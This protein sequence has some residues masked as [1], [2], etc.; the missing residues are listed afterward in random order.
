MDRKCHPGRSFILSVA[1]VRLAVDSVAR[2]ALRRRAAAGLAQLVERRLPKPK[3]ASS[4]LVSRSSEI[5]GEF[6]GA[7]SELGPVWTKLLE[8]VAQG[9]DVEARALAVC[10][11]HEVLSSPAVVLAHTVL[12]GGPHATAKA[13]E[14]A[15]HLRNGASPALASLPAARSDHGEVP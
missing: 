5:I 2:R 12:A 9:H 15:E 7:K 11:A 13:I 10:L 14:L 3:V 8:A 1:E 4:R 6:A